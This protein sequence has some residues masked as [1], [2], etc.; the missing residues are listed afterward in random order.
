MALTGQAGL[1]GMESVFADCDLKKRKK[2]LPRRHVGF[3]TNMIVVM[4]T[5]KIA[6]IYRAL[7]MCL[8]LFGAFSVF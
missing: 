5:T 4:V 1:R 8:L 7:S 2:G 6:D 3:F